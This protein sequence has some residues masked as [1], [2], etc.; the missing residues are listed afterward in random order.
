MEAG[1]VVNERYEVVR[2][3]G[4]GG[5]GE[6]LLVRDRKRDLVRCAL[7]VLSPRAHDPGLT[8][9]FRSEFLLLAGVRHPSIVSVRDFGSLDTGE[10]YFTMDYQ[11]KSGLAVKKDANLDLIKMARQGHFEDLSQMSGLDFGKLLKVEPLVVDD[12]EPLRAEVVSFLNAVRGGAPPAVTG[13]DGLAAVRL[14]E[15]IV[16]SIQKREWGLD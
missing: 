10:S 11:K 13:E 16:A 9:L 7:K 14:A 12:V 8:S 1:A 6:L 5:V 2:D 15:D 3:L 4:R